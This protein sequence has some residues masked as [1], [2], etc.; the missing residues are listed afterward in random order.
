VDG[1]FEYEKRRS[2][3]NDVNAQSPVLHDAGTGAF[4]S[5]PHRVFGATNAPSDT[6]V[7]GS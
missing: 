5:G 2:F 6:P 3:V 7:A 4:Y 1:T